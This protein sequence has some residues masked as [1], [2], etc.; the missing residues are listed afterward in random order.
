MIFGK[1]SGPYT[2]FLD[3]KSFSGGCFRELSL[4]RA[5]SILEE[6]SVIFFVPV[7]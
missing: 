1:S 5:S 2:L 7:V 4:S 6:Y 3:T